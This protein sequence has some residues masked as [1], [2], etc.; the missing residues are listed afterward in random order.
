MFQFGQFAAKEQHVIPL[1]VHRRVEP[2]Q[3]LDR[4]KRS[5]EKL[6]MQTDHNDIFWIRQQSN[7]DIF[8]FRTEICEVNREKLIEEGL[9][10]KRTK[11][12]PLSPHPNRS[13][14]IKF[15]FY[16]QSKPTQ[17]I[18]KGFSRSLKDKLGLFT[19]QT[20]V[21]LL[22]SMLISVC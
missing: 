21:N 10:D 4:L 13:A 22:Q 9:E 6:G 7:R 14:K 5:L 15:R 11:S 17:E 1:P 12:S 16:G 2:N 20:M 8:Y 18:T 19:E 3:A